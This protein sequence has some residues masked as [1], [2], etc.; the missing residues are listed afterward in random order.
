MLLYGLFLHDFQADIGHIGCAQ[1]RTK[2]GIHKLLVNLRSTLMIYNGTHISHF[3]MQN[4]VKTQKIETFAQ[5]ITFTPKH[6]NS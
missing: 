3:Q 2:L 6:G 4:K 5:K 1:I